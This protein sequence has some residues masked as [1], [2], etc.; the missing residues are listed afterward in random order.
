MQHPPVTILEMLKGINDGY[1]VVATKRKNRKGEPVV[2]SLF[3]KLFYKMMKM[4]IP[5]EKM[6][7]ILDL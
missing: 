6:F 7:K 3:S 4:F 1:D 5:I 2:K